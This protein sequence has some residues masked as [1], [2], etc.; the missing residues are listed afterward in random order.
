M[1]RYLLP[2]L[3][4]TVLLGLHAVAAEH[5]RAEHPQAEHPT[6]EHPKADLEDAPRVIGLLFYADW[7]G[8]CKVLDP[9]LE[10]VTPEF[11]DQPILF[12]RVDL[13][14]ADTQVGAEQ[15]ARDLGLEDIYAE[16]EGRTG[17]MLLVD[18]RE[19]RVLG[20]LTHNQSEGDIRQ[21]ISQALAETGRAEHPKAE[22]PTA[23]HPR[24]EHPAEEHPKAEQEEAPRRWWQ[25]WR[26]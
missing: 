25:F 10:A 12:T 21:A 4:G 2:L 6:A 15:H 20:R 9:K 7:C 17:F 13:T 8:S 1:K 22:H 11:A 3:T 24:A 23:E 5:P 18:A 26:R 14:D 19:K 16:H